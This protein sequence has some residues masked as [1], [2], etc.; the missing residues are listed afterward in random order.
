MLFVLL[1]IIIV[2]MEFSFL[3]SKRD[4]MSPSVLTCAGYVAAVASCAY[5]ADTWGV[6]I[7]VRTAIII[8]VGLCSFI[9]GEFF[10]TYG[11]VSKTFSIEIDVKNITDSM[12][13]YKYHCGLPLWLY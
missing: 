2:L 6:N 10:A 11:I 7:G 9:V 13:I 4:I 3:M 12:I 8:T 5:N 1:I